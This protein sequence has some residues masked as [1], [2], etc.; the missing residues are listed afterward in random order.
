MTALNIRRTVTIPKFF[1]KENILAVI[2]LG[3]EV[4]NKDRVYQKFFEYGLEGVKKEI[5]KEL[6]TRGGNENTFKN[7][8]E[9]A[10]KKVK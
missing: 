10:V 2:E 7:L 8:L 1:G 5:L 3:G 4:L 9:K 6:K